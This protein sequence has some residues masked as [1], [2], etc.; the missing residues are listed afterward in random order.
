MKTYH[1]CV[2]TDTP[3][4]RSAIKM[5]LTSI[6]SQELLHRLAGV[7]DQDNIYSPHFIG[8]RIS[9]I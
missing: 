9:D 6:E 2:T 4:L 7:S 5:N 3:I 8:K 1:S